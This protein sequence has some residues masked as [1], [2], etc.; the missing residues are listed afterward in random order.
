LLRLALGYN[1]AEIAA[2]EDA[3]TSAPLDTFCFQP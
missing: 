3:T 1:Y 2:A